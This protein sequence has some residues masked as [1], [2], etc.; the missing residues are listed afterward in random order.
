[1]TFMYNEKTMNKIRIIEKVKSW[2]ISRQ[3]ACELLSCSERTIY[4]MK[5]QF[6]CFWPPWL[7]HWLKGKPSNHQGNVSKYASTRRI[8]QKYSKYHD[9]WPTLLSE[10]LDEDFW[11]EINKETLRQIM[12]KLG[13]RV[14][15]PKKKKISRQKRERSASYWTMIQFDWSYHNWFE[16]GEY[17]CL[18]CAVDDATGIVYAQFSYG[19]S[20]EEVFAFWKKYFS[21]FGKPEKIYVD[22]HATYKVHSPN[23]YWDEKRRTCFERGM[24]KLGVV[25]IFSKTPEGKWRVEKWNRT[26]QDRLVKKMRLLGIKTIEEGNQYLIT[27]YLKEHNEKFS[28]TAKEEWDN[29]TPLS[30]HEMENLEWFFAKEDVRTV[31]KDGTV[32]YKHKTYQL[33]KWIILKTRQIT[34]KESIYGN[35]RLYDWTLCLRWE[36][37]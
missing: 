8:L 36:Y 28:V 25:V 18:L 17:P 7:I 11:I 26:H 9:F 34:V 16:N 35:I 32:Q 1:M 10:H 5:K 24:R 19:E 31:K 4:R 12:I 15:K 2:V 14:A 21:L 27:K 6:D 33:K 37:S 29:H 3:E 23:D 30:E 20:F 22:C 13:I